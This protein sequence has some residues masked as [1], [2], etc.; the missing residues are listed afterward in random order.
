MI[1]RGD[2]SWIPA[3]EDAGC[4]A[5]VEVGVE[6]RQDQR[7]PGAGLV[8]RERV[9]VE[10]GPGRRCA[11]ARWCRRAGGC[12]RERVVG[13]E[14]LDHG[15]AGGVGRG[16]VVGEQRRGGL[17][18]A[19]PD[20]QRRLEGEGQ[21]VQA[22]AGRSVKVHTSAP[23]TTLGVSS[24]AWPGP[25]GWPSRAPS[26][27]R[28]A[29]ARSPVRRGRG[30]PGPRPRRRPNRHRRLVSSRAWDRALSRSVLPRVLRPGDQGEQQVAE[31]D[32]VEGVGS[33]TPS[34]WPMVV[35]PYSLSSPRVRSSKSGPRSP[36]SASAPR[37]CSS[38]ARR[39]ASS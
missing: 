35:P 6:V 31:G 37:A 32:P 34:S 2:G 33:R 13:L 19:H 1:D 39:S 23:S 4:R 28:T 12:R 24:S 20:A 38:A 3:D 10:V 16:D 14:R 26:S 9:Q 21:R 30:R 15:Q 5:P 8:D 29:A 27:S 18:L 22:P 25:S 11:T 7:H 36:R 17:E